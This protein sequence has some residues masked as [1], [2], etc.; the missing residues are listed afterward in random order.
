MDSVYRIYV[1]TLENTIQSNVLL[2]D[3]YILVKKG[4]TETIFYITIGK[5]WMWQGLLI[6]KNRPLLSFSYQII[7]IRIT[8]IATISDKLELNNV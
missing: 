4:G 8:V 2:L 7:S 5:N 6:D 3:N 1:I